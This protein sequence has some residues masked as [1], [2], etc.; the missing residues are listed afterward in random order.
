MLPKQLRL[1]FLTAFSHQGGIEKFNRAFLKACS[2]LNRD[3]EVLF[4]AHVLHDNQRD[5]DV[6]YVPFKNF[7]GYSGNI[8]YFLLRQLGVL[9]QSEALVLG[10]L[11]LAVIGYLRKLFFQKRK[12]IV[13]CHGIEVFTP[14]K[15]IRKKVL[16]NADMILAVSSFTKHQLVNLQ[17][18][19]P[20][21]ITIFPNTVDPFFQL[22]AEFSK[23]EY[24]QKRYGL[25]GHEKILF[26]LTRLNS[27]EGYKG[28]D[29]V[30]SILPVLL[31]RGIPVKY[32]L[33][34]KADEIE[35]H[36]VN[37]LLNEYDLN[38]HVIVT[39][40]LPDHEITDHFLL[41]DAFVMPSKGEGF[42]IVYIEAMACGLPVLAGN[43]DGSTEAL[44]F[45][46]L[47][48]LV[49]P[50]SLSQITDA[51]VELL[52]QKKNASDLQ[53]KVIADFSYTLFCR[54]LQQL[55]KTSV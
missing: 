3:G 14:L 52:E 15:G 5:L 19:A 39:G 24:L 13:I 41:A 2:D 38:D 29:K 17:Q 36:R 23:P 55:L 53:K 45:G 35:M 16:Q 4:S 33:A 12:L 10:H 27:K 34:G 30:L 43:K 37:Q 48:T 26:T 7:K 51:V 25:N 11:N 6:R 22:P 9:F 50:D 42:G 54:R 40:F 31:K 44:Q 1:L 8:I 28:Y 20:E 47:G 32:I 46:K 49:D 21:K 18:I